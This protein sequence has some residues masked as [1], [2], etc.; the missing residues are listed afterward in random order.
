MFIQSSKLPDAAG[1]LP[2]CGWLT[3]STSSM[4]FTL[5]SLKP[6]TSNAAFFRLV[7]CLP[8]AGKLQF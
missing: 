1:L 3:L 2:F 4:Y 5:S 7:P 8:S 6:V